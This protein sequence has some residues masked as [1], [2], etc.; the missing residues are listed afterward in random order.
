MARFDQL[1]TAHEYAYDAI[2]SINS[3]KDQLYPIEFPK[4]GEIMASFWNVNDQL[5]KARELLI[6]Q[7]YYLSGSGSGRAEAGKDDEGDVSIGQKLILASPKQTDQSAT[8]GREIN[9]NRLIPGPIKRKREPA[10]TARMITDTPEASNGVAPC[11]ESSLDLSSLDKSL[12][13][14][15]SKRL[16]LRSNARKS[17]D[18]SGPRVFELPHRPKS[19]SSADV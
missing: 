10:L 13:Q 2:T 11:G 16:C 15:S 14:P 1:L 17:S 18:T 6:T 19:G 9:P 12:A 3:A 8:E 4:K 7:Y 5:N